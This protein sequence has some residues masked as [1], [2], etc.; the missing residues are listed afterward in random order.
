MDDLPMN[1]SSMPGLSRD[2]ISGGSAAATIGR[3]MRRDATLGAGK[4][5]GARGRRY[6]AARYRA[7]NVADRV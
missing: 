3:R 7:A 2:F 4:N 1:R 5:D 6:G